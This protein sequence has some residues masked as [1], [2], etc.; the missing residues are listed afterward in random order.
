MDLKL[1]YTTSGEHTRYLQV[2]F[3]ITY[4]YLYVDIFTHMCTYVY[5]CI[6]M[7]TY[8]Y[9]C[10]CNT[11]P[12]F[13]PASV[14]GPRLFDSS[15]AADNSLAVA[16]CNCLINLFRLVGAQ[17]C[18]VSQ[19]QPLVIS[20][21]AAHSCSPNRNSPDVVVAQPLDFNFRAAPPPHS[22]LFRRS[23]TA[24]R[25]DFPSRPAAC[26]RPRCSQ[27]LASGSAVHAKTS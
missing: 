20:L 27:M 14:V 9:L 23:G 5:I 12:H 21:P 15:L 7:C 24:A 16:L 19:A 1:K 18:P 8:K 10:L 25:L 13:C 4:D 3:P 11:K 22:C 2:V 6:H 26:K 17:H